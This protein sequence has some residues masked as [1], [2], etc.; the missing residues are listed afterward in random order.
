MKH[1]QIIL[2]AVA[3]AAMPALAVDWNSPDSVAQTAIEMNP[4]LAGLTAQIRA[5]QQ[6]VA[7]AG[8]Q[9]N[10]MLMGG[11]Q[12]QTIDLSYDFMTMYMVGA[13]QTLVRKSRRNAL[14]RSAE[15]DVEVLR[16]EYEARHAEV[17]REVRT[18]YIDAAAAQNE[19]VATE[20]IKKLLESV[21]DSSRIRYETGAVPQTDLIRAMLE[22]SNLEHQLILL[23]RQRSA[24]VARLLPLLQLPPGT[25]VPSFSLKHQMEHP[26]ELGLDQT[27]PEMTP[28][29]AQLQAQVARADQELRLARLATKPD[30]NIEATYGFRPR[31]IDMIAVV[32]RIELP[33][34]RATLIEPRI[35][36]AMAR[37]DAA[38]QQIETMRQGLRQD[39][40]TAVVLRN[41][42]I[43][44]IIL[45]VDKLVPM[46]KLGF[47][48]AL[49]SYQSGKTMLDAV[50]GSLRTY[51]SLNVDYYDFLRQQMEAE[52]DI[53]AIRHGAR[54]GIAGAAAP[55]SS[56]PATSGAA[57]Q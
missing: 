56:A 32:G 50:L 9:P 48:S 18:A 2:L 23:R 24:A 38:L 51:I 45:H 52:A 43:E 8:S 14:R 5:A 27:L 47:D 12:N 17:E 13:S 37:R 30:L 20:E 57:M 46:A 16:H 53:D 54:S 7:P 33:L 55:M 21:T 41:E 25:P 6:R 34:R 3:L 44:Q 49:V 19:I 35:R 11:V 29:V 26:H 22:Q 31:D 42:A 10:P 15:L 36:E 4:S 28:A 40:G 1:V 39:L